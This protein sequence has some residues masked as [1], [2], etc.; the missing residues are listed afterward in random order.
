MKFVVDQLP[1]YE[2]RCPFWTM[3]GDNV[4]DDKCPRY[5]DK[6][7]VCSDENP[8]ECQLLIEA[9]KITRV[10]HTKKS[11]DADATD[12]CCHTCKH[13]LVPLATDILTGRQKD[14]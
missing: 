8:H 10:K 12:R 7:Y 13:L 9:E 1:Y 14:V 4:S 6:N 3:C 5:W 2:E 11:N